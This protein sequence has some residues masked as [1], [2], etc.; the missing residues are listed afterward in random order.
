MAVGPAIAAL[1]ILFFSFFEKKN[2]FQAKLGKNISPK[3]SPI[4]IQSDSKTVVYFVLCI[5]FSNQ[6]E[7]E[8]T[9]CR[10]GK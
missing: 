8:G 6:S 7:T 1:Y 5:F 2:I 10:A 9:M 3:D 4:L